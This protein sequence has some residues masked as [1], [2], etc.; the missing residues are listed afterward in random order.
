MRRLQPPPCRAHAPS[1][2]H[3]QR[4]SSFCSSQTYRCPALS[5][6]YS[7]R[8]CRSGTNVR[9]PASRSLGQVLVPGT[10][11]P[12]HAGSC[13]MHLHHS[14][15]MA[16]GTQGGFFS[17]SRSNLIAGVA[18]SITSAYHARIVAL[19]PAAMTHRRRLQGGDRSGCQRRPRAADRHLDRHS[20]TRSGSDK[21]RRSSVKLSER[22]SGAIY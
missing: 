16:S 4:G 5:F 22:L 13:G 17:N 1:R 18:R 12:S 15:R 20:P 7:R 6:S 9:Q 3:R 8:E 21:F 2:S 19:F 10:R 14:E 11:R